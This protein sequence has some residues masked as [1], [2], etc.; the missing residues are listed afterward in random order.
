MN[1][2]RLLAQ[3]PLGP[4]IGGSGLGPF[5]KGDYSKETGAVTGLQ[6]VTRAVSSIIGVMTVAAGIWFLFNI[7][8]GGINWI[9]AGGEKQAL[10]NSRNRITNAMIGLVIVVAG[11][12]ILALAGQFLGFDILITKPEDIINNIFHGGAEGGGRTLSTP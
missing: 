11:W 8:I 6:N 5:G 10:E 3:T 12:T 7:L 9:S 4:Q 2:I 1:I